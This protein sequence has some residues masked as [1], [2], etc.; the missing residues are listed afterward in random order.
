MDL[1]EKEVNGE[2]LTEERMV[3]RWKYNQSIPE[4]FVEVSTKESIKQSELVRQREETDMGVAESATAP[5]GPRL[6]ELTD[7]SNQTPKPEQVGQ[8]AR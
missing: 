6:L 8:K 7:E 5:E 2:W 3:K 1:K 4:F